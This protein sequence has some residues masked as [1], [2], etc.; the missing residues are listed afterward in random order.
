L[1]KAEGFIFCMTD[2]EASFFRA[3]LCGRSQWSRAVTNGDGLER[4]MSERP[5]RTR[6]ISFCSDLIIPGEVIED[7]VFECFNFHSG[8]PE[9]PGYRPTTF[10]IV[11]KLPAYG[12]TFHRMTAKV[13]AGPIYATR[14]FPLPPH[15]TQEGV[16][17][18]V[19]QHLIALAK[20]LSLCLAEY[21][22]IFEPNGEAWSGRPTT[23]AEYERLPQFQRI[24]SP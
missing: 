5:P 14:R 17:V 6:L 18:L 9:R 3:L 24:G 20:D 19:Y 13:D 1:A 22:A 11:Q 21:D 8:P 12:V 15:A 23:R 16:D 2:A 4:A 10:A 7:L